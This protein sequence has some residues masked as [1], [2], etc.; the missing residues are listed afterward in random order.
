MGIRARRLSVAA[1]ASHTC[2]SPSISVV[3]AEL[4]EFR[5]QIAA[6]VDKWVPAVAEGVSVFVAVEA[7]SPIFSEVS[8]AGG[9]REEAALEGRVVVLKRG[10]NGENF[11]TMFLSR[12]AVGHFVKPGV[13]GISN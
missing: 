6:R 4:A 7:M 8:R 13:G 5:V 1:V 3:L 11:C 10:T 12:P 2:L 9:V